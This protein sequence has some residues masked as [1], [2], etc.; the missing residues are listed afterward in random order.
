MEGFAALLL[1]EAA[2]DKKRR[3]AAVDQDKTTTTTATAMEKEDTSTAAAAAAASFQP[4][5][6]FRS[7]H[8]EL[9]AVVADCL[10]G[11]GTSNDDD[12]LRLVVVGIVPV[13]L[14][15]FFQHSQEWDQQ[16]RASSS[17]STKKGRGTAKRSGDSLALMQ[18]Q[19]FHH[20]VRPLL[21]L[22]GAT[23]TTTDPV[24]SAKALH[25]L[26]EML[27]LV[28]DYDA[29]TPSQQ[30]QQ[31]GYQ[32]AFLQ[33][34]AAQILKIPKG[35][36]T[37][38]RILLPD[39]ILS[40]KTLLRLNHT[41]IE[42]SIVDAMVLGLDGGSSESSMSAILVDF[43]TAC[44]DTYRLLRQQRLIIS[45]M[46][47]AVEVLTKAT[48]REGLLLLNNLLNQR[49]LASALATAIQ[50]CP[51]LE[52]KELVG[53]VNGWIIWHCDAAS[54][55][56]EDAI[57]TLK[58]NVAV[59]LSSF[60][61]RNVLVD[62]FTAGEVAD[63]SKMFVNESVCKIAEAGTSSTSSTV[64]SAFLA[65]SLTLCGLALD[66][67]T[68]CVF[69]LGSRDQL[70]LP[71]PV[72]AVI[73]SVEKG[74]NS[75]ELCS[76]DLISAVGVLSCHRLRE[77]HSRIYEE[78]RAT[79]ENPTTSA[80]KDA[81]S[82]LI[83]EATRVAFSIGV[84]AE[85]LGGRQ[86]IVVAQHFNSWISYADKAHIDQFLTW[87]IQSASIALECQIRPD[88]VPERETIE[89]EEAEVGV[90]L[91]NDVSFFEHSQVLTGISGAGLSVAAHS[92]ASAL[93]SSNVGKKN[94]D[95]S[96]LVLTPSKKSL[97][98]RSTEVELQALVKG[99]TRVQSGTMN[100]A[101]SFLE[102]ALYPILLINGIHGDA[103][104]K[105]DALDILDTVFRIDHL[106][107]S[108]CSAN[109]ELVPSAISVVTAL[110]KTA[111]S[112]LMGAHS[113]AVFGFLCSV[114]GLGGFACNIMTSTIRLLVVAKD[115]LNA[116]KGVQD[117]LDSTGD[118]IECAARSSLILSADAAKQ[119]SVGLLESMKTTE[120]EWE[121]IALAG[122]VRRL[123]EGLRFNEWPS[124]Y[125]G[126]EQN[127]VHQQLHAIF[128][129]AYKLS[130]AA[131]KSLPLNG[132]RKVVPVLSPSDD[133]SLERYLLLGDL[134]RIQDVK[135]LPDTSLA[136]R[137]MQDFC[138]HSLG[139]ASATSATDKN[140]NDLSYL[141]GCIAN[142]QPTI[143]LALHIVDALVAEMQN[144]RDVS[145]LDACLCHAI[146]TLP[147]E[148]VRAVAEKMLN[149]PPRSSMVSIASRI[150]LIR[151]LLR[152]ADGADQN[153]VLASF[154]WDM[155]TLSLKPLH[156]KSPEE[157]DWA[158]NA[159]VASS[160]AEDLIRRRDILTFRE[161]DVALLLSYISTTLGPAGGKHVEAAVN[162]APTE[163]EGTVV[164]SAMT[165]LFSTIFQRY[166]KQLY[167][168]VPSAISV[169]HSFLRHAMYP[170]ENQ[171]PESVNERGQ[172]FARICEH[173]VAHKDIYKKH[174]VGIVL[175][176]VHALA[177]S[178]DLQIR[179][180]LIPAIYSLLDTMSRYETQQLD[181]HMDNKAKALFRGIIHQGYQT[182][183]TY[184]GQ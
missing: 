95:L 10:S 56:D 83:S 183:H 1:K 174:V 136:R 23:T 54:F 167:A 112:L 30:D 117:L 35:D 79:M 22:V 155:F 160:L 131:V 69:W 68:R 46:F 25:S 184:K 106:C 113:E 134:L 53:V 16:E 34:I 38:Q 96:R 159:L 20:W 49:E 130:L 148:Q 75:T 76:D 143:E 37:A 127:E 42:S 161:R 176:F 71:G 129:S 73:Q 39:A 32:Y 116:N 151:L 88:S 43:F 45:S 126:S 9:L 177:Q 33:A 150:R 14:R 52:V 108:L 157:K 122:M 163:D 146:P 168:C 48:N 144:P 169:L 58:L 5:S 105:K 175:E 41:L 21:A 29:Y 12:D 147:A 98:T 114:Q 142:Y 171:S 19:L 107:R 47:N 17:S 89:D 162:D 91:L 87:V 59:R 97:L 40:L 139:N 28:L 72:D 82:V 179:N 6:S 99:Y 93:S 67:H 18:F 138:I 84:M 120:S 119:V 164:F 31:D 170:T 180:S 104:S 78:D 92:I 80:D 2:L 94:K 63:H 103:A 77:L 11:S 15:G 153:E 50:N 181:A 70:K 62:H 61:L 26:Q 111:R 3:V 124:L 110:R 74:L 154:G 66:L 4:K 86:W 65:T 102:K 36:P 100:E 109:L 57:L 165:E 64:R 51:I 152:Y 137:E 8:E 125:D 128:E 135:W 123:L 178:L 172:R 81:S 140:W 158:M 145:L 55:D 44:V 118:L 101:A 115:A 141:V 149:L 166:T 7:Y 85:K 132:D 156:R 13:L 173:L 60:L 133:A 90:Y 24:L 27:Q 121:T 182:V